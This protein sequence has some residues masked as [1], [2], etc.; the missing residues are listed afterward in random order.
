MKVRIDEL[1]VILNA[2]V[3]DNVFSLS[4][5]SSYSHKRTIDTNMLQYIHTQICWKNRTWSLYLPSRYFNLTSFLYLVAWKYGVINLKNESCTQGK[6]ILNLFKVQRES[7]FAYT[8]NDIVQWTVIYYVPSA[9]LHVCC[10][11]AV[12]KLRIDVIS[13]AQHHK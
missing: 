2:H 11:S 10:I 5:S 4:Y 6:T 12:D 8:W 3:D 7:L 1:Y 13:V 9:S